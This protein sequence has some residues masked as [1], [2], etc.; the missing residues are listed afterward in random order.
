[1][2]VLA[3]GSLSRRRLPLRGVLGAAVDAPGTRLAH[4]RSVGG[5]LVPPVRHDRARPRRSLVGRGQTTAR[6]A[7]RARRSLRARGALA[8]GDGEDPG[9][10]GAAR[11]LAVDL[12]APP[13]AEEHRA[14]RRL[15]RDAADT[16][17]LKVHL[18]AGLVLELDLGADADDSALARLRL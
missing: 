4:G 18:L 2:R 16:R 8:L 3:A 14:Q 9:A 1:L 7:G 5:L 10:P 11:R 13:P 12:V 15:G 17:D 6:G